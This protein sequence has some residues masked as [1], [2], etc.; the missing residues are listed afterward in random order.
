MQKGN[1]IDFADLTLKEIGL[2]VDED[3]H[4]IDEETGMPITAKGK[5]LKFN[6]GAVS[7]T[8]RDEINY[9]PLN[10]PKLMNFLFGYYS[11]KLEAEG[12]RGVDICYTT[13]GP[14]DKQIL[15]IK[16]G[17]DA[18]ESEPY[19]NESVRIMDVICKLN[20]SDTDVSIYDSMPENKPRGKRPIKK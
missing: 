17:D 20:D 9:D 14:E 18:L 16:T 3:N 10:N 6:C 1:I 13:N 12:S 2:D 11:S 19:Y 15:N 8:T 7:R 5:F 4:I